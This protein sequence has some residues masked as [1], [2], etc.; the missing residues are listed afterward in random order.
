MSF[1]SD[2]KAELAK[3]F[4]RSRH[5]QLA[6][7]AGMLEM[8]GKLDPDTGRLILDTDNPVLKEKYEVLL[9]KAFGGVNAVQS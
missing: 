7:L 3:Q 9:K 5:C 2:V 8:E 4:G 1:S 6:E